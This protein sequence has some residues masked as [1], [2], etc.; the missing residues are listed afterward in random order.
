[1]SEPSLALTRAIKA[2]LRGKTAAGDAIYDAVKVPANSFPRITLGSGQVI[3]ADMS[4][5]HSW[6][7]YLQVDA[8]SRTGDYD[9][10]K[11]MAGAIHSALHHAGLTLTGFTLTDIRVPDMVF[12]MEQDGG[13]S[14]ARLPVVAYLE[15]A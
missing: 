10:V 5:G 2:H 9:E 3:T 13:I 11:E 1:M 4:C 12:S 14:R 7:I 6:E 8:W 15:G